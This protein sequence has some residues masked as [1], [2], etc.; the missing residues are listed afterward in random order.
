MLD[1][2]GGEHADGHDDRG[3]QQHQ[4][5]EAIDPDAVIYVESRDPGVEFLKLEAIGRGIE[6]VPEQ[7]GD[8]EGNQ[9]ECERSPADAAACFSRQSRSTATAPTRAVRSRW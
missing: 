7:Q 1:L 3:E 2:P 9:A 5:P 4:K 6:V 8:D